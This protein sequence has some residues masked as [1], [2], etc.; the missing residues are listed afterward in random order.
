MLLKPWAPDHAFATG[1][2]FCFNHWPGTRRLC[3]ALALPC[4][5]RRADCPRVVGIYCTW[6]SDDI[7]PHGARS[8][9]RCAFGYSPRIPIL[10]RGCRVCRRRGWANAWLGRRAHAWHRLIQCALGESSC[11]WYGCNQ[12]GDSQLVNSHVGSPSDSLWPT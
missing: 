2:P 9:H 4:G 11:S 3:C 6:I 1:S 7:G 12:G 5:R 10:G 8:G